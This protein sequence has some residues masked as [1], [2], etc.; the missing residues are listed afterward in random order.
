MRGAFRAYFRCMRTRPPCSRSCFDIFALGCFV[1]LGCTEAADVPDVPDLEALQRE[2]D[3]PTGSLDGVDLRRV[4]DAFPELEQVAGALR[5]ADPLIEN[6]DDAREVANERSGSGVELRGALTIELA[7]PGAAAE[8]R[9]DAASSGSLSFDL[10]VDRGLI[11]P[12]FWATAR[13]CALRGALG[14]QAF[15]VELDGEIAVDVGAPISLGRAWQRGRT[16]LSMRG[17]VSIDTLI[18]RDMSARYGA[19]DFEYLQDLEGG[20]VVLLVTEDGIGIRDRD[21]TWFCERGAGACGSR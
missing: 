17:N 19:R 18:L 3:D 7:C 5:T 21:T 9:F 10:A 20:S 8:P 15:P 14:S 11:K 4:L 6:I 2:Y 12:S 16:L 13:R 1:A